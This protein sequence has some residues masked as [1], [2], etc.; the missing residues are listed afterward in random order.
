MASKGQLTGTRGVYLVAAE[1][2]RLGFI[3]S[4]TSRNAAAVDI[5]VTD[6]VCSRSFSIQ[7]KTNTNIFSYWLLTKKAKEI[8]SPSYFYVFVNLRPKKDGEVIEYYIVPSSVVAKK[9]IREK[10]KS[11]A[12]EW[13]SF[14]LKD[15]LPFKD[16]WDAFSRIYTS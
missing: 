14:C 5:L 10:T 11:T 9:T 15:A 16:K 13:Y 1:L 3:C 2:S 8:M 7:V 12:S 4:P 6:E